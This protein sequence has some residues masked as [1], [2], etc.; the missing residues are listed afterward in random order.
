MSP[1]GTEPDPTVLSI[2]SVQNQA[3]SNGILMIKKTIHIFCLVSTDESNQADSRTTE[4]IN[5]NVEVNR[6]WST[7]K[8]EATE[9]PGNIMSYLL[10]NYRKMM[11]QCDWFDI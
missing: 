8:D 9:V 1:M 3:D 4:D 6:V 10:G 7:M 5:V 11:S 2:H